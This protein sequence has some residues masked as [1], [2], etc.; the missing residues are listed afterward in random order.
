MAQ[1]DETQTAEQ[2]PNSSDSE[3]PDLKTLKRLHTDLRHTHTEAL[4]TFS[5]VS[6]KSGRLLQFNGTILG[7]LAGAATL[8]DPNIPKYINKATALGVGL[9]ISSILIL[10]WLHK[11]EPVIVGV[12]DA[13]REIAVGESDEYPPLNEPAYLNW[14][15]QY[16]TNWIDKAA[17]RNKSKAKFL[18]ISEVCTVAGILAVLGGILIVFL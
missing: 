7:I 2:S 14:I 5:D 17:E 9:I 8:A 18:F 15:N 16:Y 6:R 10:V 11:T 13:E 12:G 4:E 3:T 1:D